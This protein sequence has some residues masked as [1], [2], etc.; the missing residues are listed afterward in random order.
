VPGIGARSTRNSGTGTAQRCSS[1]SSLL[2]EL[3]Q[4]P[5]RAAAARPG[6]P[7]EITGRQRQKFDVREV[8]EVQDGSDL[9][10]WTVEV[11]CK[12]LELRPENCNKM[13]SSARG[14]AQAPGL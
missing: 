5:G 12:H 9:R 11:R 6:E 1:S 10:V 7:G 8:A 13:S 14:A 4:A 2:I 3:W